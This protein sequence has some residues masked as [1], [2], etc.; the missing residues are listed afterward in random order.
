MPHSKAVFSNQIHAARQKQSKLPDFF[1]VSNNYFLT[2][3]KMGQ[4]IYHFTTILR[5]FK[6]DC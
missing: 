2:I 5:I 3:E 6:Y 4:G 1:A